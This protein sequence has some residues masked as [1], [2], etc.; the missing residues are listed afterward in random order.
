MKLSHAD[1][2]R[3]MERDPE[4]WLYVLLDL[5]HPVRCRGVSIW[6]ADP[7]RLDD[8]MM[9]RHDPRAEISRFLNGK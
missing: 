4:R 9:Y 3:A 1:A 7:E 5:A 8:C 6:A 2:R